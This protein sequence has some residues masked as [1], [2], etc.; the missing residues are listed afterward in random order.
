CAPRGRRVERDRKVC[1]VSELAVNAVLSCAPVRRLIPL[2]R[3]VDLASRRGSFRMQSVLSRPERYTFT[4]DMYSHLRESHPETHVGYWTFALPAGDVVST[5]LIDLTTIGPGSVQR[6]ARQG[7]E[8]AVDA[9]TNPDYRFDP[10]IGIQL[11]L[12]RKG[13]VV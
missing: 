12:R 6:E 5:F 11:V 3:T 1:H 7:H 13:E 2:T 8:R 4:V 9:W 10:I